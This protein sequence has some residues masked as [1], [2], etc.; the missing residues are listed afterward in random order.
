MTLLSPP[1]LA[2]TTAGSALPALPVEIGDEPRWKRRTYTVIALLV[3]AGFVAFHH[4][5]WAPAHPG[6][7][8]NGYLVGGKNLARTG[9]MRLDP[10]SPITKAYD[11]YRYIGWMW[12]G[13]DLDTPAERY[14]P[15]YP[16][17]QPALV[18][19]T[20]KIGGK[21]H[22]V[23]LAYCLSPAAMA[24]ALWATFLLGRLVANSLAGLFAMI[25]L[26]TSPVA[27]EL[28]NNPN[29]HA[30]SLFFVTWGALLI[31]KW[32]A[33]GGAWRAC[34]GGFL[35]GYA[36][37][38]RY[39]EASMILPLAAAAIVHLRWKSLRSWIEALLALAWW[40]LPVLALL[41]VN[42]K[43][44]GSLTGYDPTNESK[45]F[46]LEY[47]SDNWEPMLRQISTGGLF[48]IAPLGLAG[49][50]WMF[51]VRWKTALVL[52]LWI[53]PCVA[54]YTLYYWAPDDYNIGYLRFYLSIFPPLCVCAFWLLLQV[55][56][57]AEQLL[58]APFPL[59]RL[60]SAATV[61]AGAVLAVAIVEQFDLCSYEIDSESYRNN[62]LAT[63]TD[64]IVHTIPAGSVVFSE[65]SSGG[66]DLFNHLQFAGDYELYSP[67]LFNGMVVKML[68]GD[69]K[70]KSDNANPL[71]PGR[72]KVLFNHLHNLN[73]EQLRSAQHD[74]IRSALQQ[75]RRVFFIFAQSADPGRMDTW[76]PVATAVPSTIKQ[77]LGAIN[78]NRPRWLGPSAGNSEFTC[79]VVAYWRPQIP[80]PKK[81]PVHVQ[82]RWGV[83]RM[84]EDSS[85]YWQIIEVKKAPAR[86][87]ATSPA[88]TR[89]SPDAN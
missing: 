63:A 53:F 46:S 9:S 41:C 79:E 74:L 85:L 16:I 77:Q 11:P 59:K 17:G 31:L 86:A 4:A 65:I 42:L 70:D 30:L 2:A 7:D 47:F 54:I 39:S 52:A 13:V 10:I 24:G 87:M 73:G 29:S 38:I 36:T 84:G 1:P 22:G 80:T 55:V 48:F 33:S 56:P 21:D 44:M 89:T 14:Y 23:E 8:Q 27:M 49:L 37:T 81:P 64:R 26:A 32:G 18:A 15:K 66:R 34:L 71:D 78:P 3:L 28:A 25:A 57:A 45:G 68:T 40:A 67:W 88:T 60:R 6:V 76:L 51:F 50:A 58:A 75:D 83:M 20:L 43:T 82:G 72:R 62:Q 5:Y 19:L 69:A 61:A 12:V 35:L